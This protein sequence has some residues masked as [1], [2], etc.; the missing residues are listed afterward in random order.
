MNVGFLHSHVYFVQ[1]QP[2]HNIYNQPCSGVMGD[3]NGDNIPFTAYDVNTAI[4]WN[5]DNSCLVDPL[6][7]CCNVAGLSS[8][9]QLL[10]D[11]DVII[12]QWMYA[13]G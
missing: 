7:G 12:M 10:T 6:P 2:H 9:I 13:N 4:V 1:F 11:N 3:V 8:P 5:N